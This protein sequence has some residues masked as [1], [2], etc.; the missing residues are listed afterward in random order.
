MNWKYALVWCSVLLTTQLWGQNFVR[1]ADLASHHKD[2][3]KAIEVTKLKEKIFPAV[4]LEYKNLEHLVISKGA[5]ENLEGLEKMTS[6]KTLKI[7]KLDLAFFPKEVINLVNL[8]VL[9]ISRIDFGAVP[10]EIGQLSNLT[11]LDLYGAGI[12]GLPEEMQNLTNLKRL[13][14]SGV[15]LTAPEQ[16]AIKEML[17]SVKVRMDAPC[18][19]MSH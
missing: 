7:D 18:N 16:K 3:V 13:D 2:S 12:T 14:L 1:Y 4:L 10:S 11:F 5:L 17:P 19:C 9:T 15:S 6:L 8:E